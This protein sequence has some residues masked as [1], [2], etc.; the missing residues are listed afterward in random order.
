MSENS[1]S[2]KSMR[3]RYDRG[4]P[5]LARDPGFA[6]AQ[7]RHAFVSVWTQP[8]TIDSLSAVRQ[9]EESLA[10]EAPDGLVVLTVMTG[11]A[12]AIGTRERE[13]AQRLAQRFD[14]TTQA[15]AYVIEGSGFRAAAMRAVLAGLQLLARTSHPVRVFSDVPTAVEWLGGRARPP[16]APD[17]LADTVEQARAAI[18]RERDLP[19]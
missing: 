6:L 15:A 9:C 13:E 19:S 3:V 12:F 2:R 10:R 16:I 1:L 11:T 4:M 17:D 8:S 5:V 7:C 14:K 18:G